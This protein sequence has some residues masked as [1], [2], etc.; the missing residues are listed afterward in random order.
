MHLRPPRKRLHATAWLLALLPLGWAGYC[1]T[2]G[3]PPTA[4]QTPEAAPVPSPATSAN[5]ALAPAPAKGKK[6]KAAP[7]RTGPDEPGPEAQFVGKAFCGAPA[8]HGSMMPELQTLRHSHYLSDPRFKDAAGCEVCHG[9][10]SDH[11]ADPEH[12]KIPK[13]TVQTRDIAER[14]NAVCM[15]CH[16]ETLRKPHYEATEH[17]RSG[18]S[19]ATC[20]EVHYDL[21]TPYMLRLPGVKGPAGQ[22]QPPADTRHA[23]HEKSPA[24]GATPA[25]APETAAAAGSATADASAAPGS[26]PEPP[27]N[28]PKLGAAAKTR[29]PIPEWR[30]SFPRDNSAVTHDQAV[31]ELCSSCHRRELTELRQFSHHPVFEGRVKCTDCHSPH[32]AERGKSLTGKTVEETCLRCHE[33]RRGPFV[34]EHDPVKAGGIGEGCLECHRPHGSPNRAM[35]VMFSRGLCIQCHTDIQQQPTHRGRN[36]DCWRAGC[37]TAI[38][39][40]N[41]SL[42]LLRE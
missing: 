8:C 42:Y 32:R 12:R 16:Q 21:H 5:E 3:L 6:Q 7:M 15:Q 20:H 11:M 13:F 39:G 27:P 33:N 18:M 24:P 41:H 14:V 23:R 19:C 34:F 4:A 31:N 30:T 9:P 38:H 26:T 2:A 40:S 22:P 37:H 1:C 28:L 25:A 36:G 29:V 10:A 17:A 35:T